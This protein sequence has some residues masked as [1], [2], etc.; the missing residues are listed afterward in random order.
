MVVFGQEWLQA[1]QLNL[2][3]A[4]LTDH[5]IDQFVVWWCCVVVKNDL[6]V[7]LDWLQPWLLIWIWFALYCMLFILWFVIWWCC[8]WQQIFCCGCIQSRMTSRQLHMLL[9]SSWLDNYLHC[10]W[11]WNRF[12]QEWLVVVDHG[13]DLVVVDLVVMLDWLQPWLLIWMFH[14]LYN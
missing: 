14:L 7:M 9:T 3:H 4:W 8:V 11:P 10:C 1:Q 5:G 6:V 12:G 13:I 2:V